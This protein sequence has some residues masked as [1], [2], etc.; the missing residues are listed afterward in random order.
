MASIQVAAYYFPNYHI[1]PRNERAH[2]PRWTEWELL[3]AARPR[4]PQHSQPKVPLWGYEDESDP[5]IFSKKIQAGVAAGI[6]TF[7][8]DWYW[9]EGSPFLQRALEQGFL[10]S[11]A[12]RQQS[13]ALMWANHDW[14]NIHPAPRATPY[15]RLFDGA[16][17]A[18][19]FVTLTDYVI[20][21][22]FSHPS[23]W[24]VNGG[25]Y[26]SIYELMRLV[27]GLGGVEQAKR[28][29]T[30]F[31]D[32]VARANLGDLHVNAVV[33][34]IQNLPNELA[35]EKPRDLLSALGIDSVT[36][37]AWIHH[38]A[39]EQFP[40]VLYAN[41]RRQATAQ[42]EDIRDRYGLPYFPNVSMGWDPSP[43]TIATDVYE[44][45]GYPYT[46]VL[47]QNTPEEFGLALR[48]AKRY[49]E[50]QSDREQILTLNAWN[51]WTEGSYLEPDTI[52][53]FGYLD[54]VKR[55]FGEI[56]HDSAVGG[57]H[58]NDRT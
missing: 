45:T 48:D 28:A 25:L 44:P 54:Q 38:V 37:Y 4:F 15:Q 33:W 51:E 53:R 19:D 13:F 46:A 29:L 6:G 36:S 56:P 47:N 9:Y 1:D 32:R 43:R 52:H 11:P 57:G 24:R 41:Y 3:R 50:S 31:R 14:L 34:G 8:F 27:Q 55:V 22:Y 26:F 23:Y 42:W 18:S 2:G 17:N 16:V 49:L 7:I 5:T 20:E 30:G 40:A 35:I 39:L 10:Q 12:N 58:S 21:R